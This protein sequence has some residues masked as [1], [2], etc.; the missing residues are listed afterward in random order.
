MK[1]ALISYQEKQEGGA[2][3]HMQMVLELKDLNIRVQRT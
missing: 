3:P 1:T 2:A